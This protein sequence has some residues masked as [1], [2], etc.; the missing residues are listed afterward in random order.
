MSRLARVL[1]LFSNSLA[2]YNGA[3]D[4]LRLLHEGKAPM[5]AED[6]VREIEGFAAREPAT[7]TELIQ[8]EAELL[9]FGERIKSS[10]ISN[11]VPHFLWHF[12]ADA[13]IRFKDPEYAAGQRERLRV[14][15]DQIKSAHAAQERHRPD[16]V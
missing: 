11:I 13:D 12:L 6:C 10:S 8:L 5:S 4:R 1:G 3:V 16:A 15:I 2:V 9:V 7:K 14:C